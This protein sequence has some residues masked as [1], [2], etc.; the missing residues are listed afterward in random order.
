MCMDPGASL[1]GLIP[2]LPLTSD[3]ALGK[4]FTS[5]YICFFT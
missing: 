5:Q 2:V 4:Y 1:L 3:V